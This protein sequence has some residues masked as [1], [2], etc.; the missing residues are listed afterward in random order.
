MECI[1]DELCNFMADALSLTH[2]KALSTEWD[3]GF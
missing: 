2:V 3:F 1:R